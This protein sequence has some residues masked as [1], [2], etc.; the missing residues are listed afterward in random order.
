MTSTNS[1]RLVVYVLVIAAFALL[2]NELRRGGLMPAATGFGLFWALALA[3]LAVGTAGLRTRRKLAWACYLLV[4]IAGIGLLGFSTP[5]TAAIGLLPL[6]AELL[7]S[8]SH[9][10]GPPS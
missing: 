10:S 6:L 8:A 4:S 3:N 2:T 5:I 9:A 1:I 7:A